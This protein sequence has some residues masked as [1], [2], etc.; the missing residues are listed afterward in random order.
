VMLW[1]C[2]A[3]TSLNSIASAVL[4]FDVHPNFSTKP[5]ACIGTI[6]DYERSQLKTFPVR[7]VL[8][9]DESGRSFGTRDASLQRE[10]FAT[11]EV[12][13]KTIGDQAYHA[14][15]RLVEIKRNAK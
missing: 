2:P 10:G 15:L 13:R 11:R 9:L 4:L 14:A 5:E 7:Y 1:Y 6:G 8:M 12:V 3:E